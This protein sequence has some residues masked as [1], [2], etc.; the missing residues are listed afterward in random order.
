MLEVKLTP[1]LESALTAH[2]R[3]ARRSKTSLVQMAV[4]S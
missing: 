3:R 1:K 4:A 2:A